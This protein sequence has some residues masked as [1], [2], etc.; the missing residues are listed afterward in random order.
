[1]NDL[2]NSVNGS[3]VENAEI[4][5]T[6]ASE[7]NENNSESYAGYYF[8]TFI[9]A[10]IGFI[11]VFFLTRVGIVALKDSGRMDLTQSRTLISCVVALIAVIL[12]MLVALAFKKVLKKVFLSE[13]F[14]YLYMGVLTTV[15]NIV[16]FEILRE[17]FE[18]TLQNTSSWKVAEIIAFI[19]AVIFAFVTNKIF[20]FKSLSLN[21]F[22]LFSEMG[23][24]VGA[25]VLTEC[26]NFLLMWFMI[27]VNGINATT[28]KIVASIVVI[29]INYIFSKFIVFKRQKNEQS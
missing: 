27:D 19:I 1:M 14:L 16:A 5:A 22:K 24:F 3:A 28:T 13:V 26:I 8:F 12:F 21:F 11:A 17:R 4:N 15:V 29:V 6:N 7:R 25:R 20:V 2:P 18:I 23:M 9:S 10:I